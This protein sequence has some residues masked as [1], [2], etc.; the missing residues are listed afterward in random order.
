VA[1]GQQRD[2]DA[3]EDRVRADD[4]A[5]G[6]MQRRLQA[7]ARLV[8]EIAVVVVGAGGDRHGAGS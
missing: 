2:E 3:L 4:R 5:P 6:L 7:A 1:A 8:G